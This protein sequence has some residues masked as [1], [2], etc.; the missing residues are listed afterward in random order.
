MEKCPE[1]LKFNPKSSW[2]WNRRIDQLWI[3]TKPFQTLSKPI[4]KLFWGGY[5]RT[6]SIAAASPWHQKLFTRCCLYHGGQSK[7]HRQTVTCSA[8]LNMPH[9]H[10][11]S[12]RG[13][14]KKI[15]KINKTDNHNNIQFLQAQWPSVCSLQSFSYAKH[16]RSRWRQKTFTL[17]SFIHRGTQSIWEVASDASLWAMEALEM[18]RY[19]AQMALPSQSWLRITVFG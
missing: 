5:D 14:K 8:S 12:H 7:R 19:R 4:L 3:T 17:H 15:G 13:W 16:N 9:C 11:S 18:E 6:L 10:N 2:V 1:F